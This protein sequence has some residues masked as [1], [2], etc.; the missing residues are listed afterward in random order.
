MYL[1]DYAYFIILRGIYNY[2]CNQCLSPLMLWVRIPLGWGVLD[3]TICDQVCQWLAAC[4]WFSPGMP[5]SS[6]NKADRHDIAEI[7]LK[8]AL[9]AMT[10]TLPP[11]F[12]ILFG[13][14]LF[15]YSLFMNVM[16]NRIIMINSAISW[17]RERIIVVYY[18]T[19]V[20]YFIN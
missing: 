9:K 19:V 3:T 1:N 6:T 4:R 10:L 18:C 20:T 15:Y 11:S 8:E 12:I 16:F 13:Q 7:L 5:F 2:P 14:V 17:Y